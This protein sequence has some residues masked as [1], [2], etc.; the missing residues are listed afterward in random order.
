MDSLGRCFGPSPYLCLQGRTHAPRHTD[1]HQCLEWDSNPPSQCLGGRRHFMVQTPRHRLSIALM[2][3]VI[4][5]LLLL[6]TPWPESVRELY[7]PNDR[8]LSAKLVQA[9]ADRGYHV[10][11]V[12]NPYGHGRILGFLDRSRYYFFQVAP[13]LY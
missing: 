11:S 8:R 7:R 3:M 9:F 5:L 13:Q 6:K 10:V 12:T 1:R 4:I 2:I